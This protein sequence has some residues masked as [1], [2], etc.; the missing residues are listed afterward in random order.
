[1]L[2]ELNYGL[3]ATVLGV[4]LLLLILAS[5]YVKSPPDTAFII[6]GFRKKTIIGKAS[7]KIPFLE[8]LDKL[9]LKLIPIDVK[10]SN[11]V[12]TADY[13][14]IQ[15]D[16]AVNVKISS[17]KDKLAMAAEKFLN[18][19][20]EYIGRVAREVLEGDLGEIVRANTYDAKVNRNINVTGVSEGDI[21]GGEIVKNIIE[22]SAQ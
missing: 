18:Q 7:I 6:S 9:S 19:N 22:D 3:I 8:R 15:V 10:T 11:A 16:A 2:P 20:I 5:G 1:M 12:P 17:D 4:I 21:L 13:I 14:N